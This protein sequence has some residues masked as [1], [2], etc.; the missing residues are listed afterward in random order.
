MTGLPT[1]R[2]AVGVP[3]RNGLAGG[4]RARGVGF[5]RT[6]NRGAAV[7]VGVPGILPGKRPAGSWRKQPA[8]EPPLPAEVPPSRVLARPGPVPARAGDLRRIPGSSVRPAAPVP[9][10]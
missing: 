10:G 7:V 8:P 2:L 5:L 3:W 1:G 6:P 9:S 4:A